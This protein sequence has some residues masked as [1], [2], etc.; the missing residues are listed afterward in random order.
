M[1]FLAGA[2]ESAGVPA[3]IRDRIT[4]G[5]PW[6]L[7]LFV[8]QPSASRAIA[9]EQGRAEPQYILRA[10]EEPEDAAAFVSV[11][12]ARRIYEAKDFETAR[13]RR[14]S[15]ES[16]GFQG[17]VS[18]SD[19][20]SLLVGT[21]LSALAFEYR[22]LAELAYASADVARPFPTNAVLY[23]V[24]HHFELLLKAL[25][26][27]ANEVLGDA[28]SNKPV[29][30]LKELVNQAKPRVL[31]L[32]GQSGVEDDV[33]AAWRFVLRLGEAD[34]NGQRFRYLTDP[35]GKPFADIPELAAFS[36]AS[37]FEEFTAAS[38][39]LDMQL[40]VAYARLHVS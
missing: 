24:R 20:A 15:L 4:E 26:T 3:T 36:L 37:F 32:G 35:Q 28:N 39:A 16:S 6:S 18:P 23:C 27:K 1:N 9:V 34:N 40:L 14:L 38:D 10:G 17:A 2:L 8:P 12:W 29:H 7:E 25:I 21:E 31:R 19:A 30:P 22:R 11:E 5:Q 33:E 13:S